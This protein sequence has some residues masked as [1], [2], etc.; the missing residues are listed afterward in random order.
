MID[1][2][3]MRFEEKTILSLR[4]LYRKHGYL[5]YKM[6]KFEEY[7]LYLRN[8]DFLV[9]DRVI[10][11]NDTNGKLMALKPDVTLSII[12]NGEDVIG[13]KQKVYYNENVYRVSDSTHRFKEIMQAGLECI[14][15]ID[16]F[17]IFEVIALAA[18]S[19]CRI[20]DSFF[21]EISNLDIV[22]S[23]LSE[24]CD[25]H[26]FISKALGYISEKNAHDLR[27]LCKKYGLSDESYGKIEPLISLYGKRADVIAGLSKVCDE[28]KLTKLRQLSS[29]LDSSAYSDRIIFDFSVVN[30]MN[31][32]N[33]FVFRGFIDG[34]SDGVLAGGQYDNMM[35]IM[36][37]SSDAVG[38]ALYLDRLDELD[39]GGEKYDVDCLLLY[40][41]STD[42]LDILVEKNKLIAEGK[43]VSCQ[44]AIPEKLRYKEAIDMRRGRNNA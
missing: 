16:I 40:G 41:E 11:F 8:K 2:S 9:S 5:P 39:A 30:D 33:G 14:G 12:K 37:R 1:G 44:K 38:F 7:E 20:S 26:D 43:S 18:E 10:A 27:S 29:L 36:S 21:I 32:Y 4:S 15:D 31:Y 23:V 35:R 3:V 25:S 28:S 22:Y 34:I 17:D 19:L 24:V 6:S 13:V 42:T